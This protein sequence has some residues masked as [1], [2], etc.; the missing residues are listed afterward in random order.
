MI[1]RNIV[2]EQPECVRQSML[3]RQMDPAPV[4]QAIALD[5][6]RRRILNEVE[7]LKSERNTQRPISYQRIIQTSGARPCPGA[8]PGHWQNRR[9]SLCG[10]GVRDAFRR[11]TIP[12]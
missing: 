8:Q 3:D 7:Q 5:A 6:E 11:T 12:R 10:T 9:G 1:D 2:R 4:D